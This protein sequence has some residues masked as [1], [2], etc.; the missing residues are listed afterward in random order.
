MERGYS[1]TV[2]WLHKIALYPES[3]NP[4]TLESQNPDFRGLGII[5]SIPGQ[6]PVWDSFSG[7][8]VWDWFPGIPRLPWIPDSRLGFF[9]LCWF[10]I[11]IFQVKSSQVKSS[12]VVARST[13]TVELLFTISIRI[14]T[15]KI[16]NTRL[17]LAEAFHLQIQ[18]WK[19]IQFFSWLFCPNIRLV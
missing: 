17:K 15:T 8:R 7:N 6:T 9:P 1:G 13:M 5:P 3:Q 14:S 18:F 19:L 2:Y 11:R 12:Q 10:R 4:P 16:Q